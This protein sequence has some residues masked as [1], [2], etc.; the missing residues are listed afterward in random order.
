[1]TKTFLLAATAAAILAG[2]ATAATNLVVN[3]SFEDGL[4]GWTIG[5]PDAQG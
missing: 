3:G 2:P 1:M 4:S 5:G